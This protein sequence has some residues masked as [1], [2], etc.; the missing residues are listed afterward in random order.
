M[1]RVT[2]H[3]K[4]PT[5][6]EEIY[7][8]DKNFCHVTKS[9]Q[10]INDRRGIWRAIDKNVPFKEETQANDN[11]TIANIIKTA[12]TMFRLLGYDEKTNTSLLFC[13]PIT[14][15]THQIREHLRVLDH[16][17][18]NDDEHMIEDLDDDQKGSQGWR[19]KM[20]IIKRF[21]GDNEKCFEYFLSQTMEDFFKSKY[22]PG[23]Y[24]IDLHA[25]HYCVKLNRDDVLE[26]KELKQKKRQMSHGKQQKMEERAKK[27]LK[28]MVNKG[29]ITEEEKEQQEEEITEDDTHFKELET[30]ED[31]PEETMLDFET[32]ILPEWCNVFEKLPNFHATLK[33]CVE[34]SKQYAYKHQYYDD[35]EK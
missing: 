26:M 5:D 20:E 12:H 10:R 31:I 28:R 32:K 35:E 3:F 7:F 23:E 6:D 25:L 15:R 13:A 17:I 30:K 33:K 8:D 18:I 21:N 19:T 24:R 11:S 14:G 4:P 29:L 2:G 34:E 27:R 9:M 16:Q 22:N 1:A